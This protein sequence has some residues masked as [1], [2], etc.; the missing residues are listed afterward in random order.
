MNKLPE[1]SREEIIQ[2]NMGLVHAC[3]QR[4]K[5]KG[6]EYDDLFQAGCMGLVKATDAFDYERGVRFLDTADLYGTYPHIRLAL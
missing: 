5:G 6:I 1:L 2:S 3:A 4:Y